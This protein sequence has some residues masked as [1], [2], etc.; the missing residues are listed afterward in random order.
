MIRSIIITAVLSMVCGIV[1]AQQIPMYS[2][3]MFN[4][5]AINPAYAG[6]QD[7]FYTSIIWREQWVGIEGAPS[8]QTL[9]LHSP[10]NNQ[11]I[12]LGGIIYQDKIGVT[13]NR[14]IIP[15]VTYRIPSDNGIMSFG[16]QAGVVNYDADYSE[17]ST[18]DPAFRNVVIN[19][20]KPTFGFGIYYYTDNYYVGA[21]IPQM[22]EI[23]ID[24]ENDSSQAVLTT[25]AFITGGYVF[26]VNADIKLKPHVLIK[27][28]NG[29]P[30]GFDLNVSALFREVLWTGVSY[31]YQESLS[32]LLKLQ[33]TNGLQFGYSYDFLTKRDWRVYSSG[34]HELMLSYKFTFEK[35]T[36]VTPKYF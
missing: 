13:T 21:S 11:K 14:A 28:A 19:T 17:I 16:L 7:A 9:A 27:Y 6:S 15:Q 4:G 33:I 32:G 10:L 29:A 24:N 31:R 12:A 1:H 3:Y 25:H 35:K 30:L 20:W 26:D 2:Q 5:S 34:T 8:T 36:T 23:Y 18:T 22:N